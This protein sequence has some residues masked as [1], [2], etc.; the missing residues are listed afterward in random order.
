MKKRA[1]SKTH[2]VPVQEKPK[3]FSRV[4]QT[5]I[6]AYTL[7]K[8][9]VIPDTI[10]KRFNRVPVSPLKLAAA[11]GVQP[12][13]TGFRMLTGA[14]IAYGLTTG[15]WN[16]K[17]IEITPLGLRI[18]HVTLEG[19]DLA[20]KREALLR[21]TVFGT[22]LRQ[23]DGRPIPRRDVAT[24]ILKTLGVP[25]DRAEA[26]LDMIIE[27]AKSVGLVTTIN[28]RDYVSLEGTA[29]QDESIVPGTTLTEPETPEGQGHSVPPPVSATTQPAGKEHKLIIP[30]PTSVVRVF[31]THG[32]NTGFIEPIKKLI[33]FGK[34]QPVVAIERQSVAKPVPDKVMDEMRTCGA[35]II[36]VD[37]ESSLFDADGKPHVVLNP[38]VLIEIGAAFALY[39]RRFILLVR[40]GVPLPSNLQGLYEVR[41]SGDTLDAN[42]TIKLLEAITDI[43]NHLLPNRYGDDSGTK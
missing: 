8:A 27:S 14:S 3:A 10:A 40:D 22:F 31:V 12:T 4:M 43:Q 26:S 33:V 28:S 1:V 42:T 19:D 35:A 20:A 5:D 13:S 21:P 36:H 23:H 2:P 18:V 41:Y 34:M 6:P 7:E 24:N 16:A 9:L 39:G 17:Q 32:K 37:A 11:M 29:A 25:D 38:N 15:G 30:P